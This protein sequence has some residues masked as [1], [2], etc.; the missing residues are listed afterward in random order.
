[1]LRRVDGLELGPGGGPGRERHEE[2]GQARL[3][4]PPGDGAQSSRSL[5]MADAGVVLQIGGVG[6]EEDGHPV[7]VIGR[8]HRCSPQQPPA[9]TPSVGSQAR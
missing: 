6:T 9:L 3:L 2:I 8:N 1:M 5:G 7:E 4:D